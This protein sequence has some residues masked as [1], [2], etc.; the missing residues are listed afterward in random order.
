MWWTTQTSLAFWQTLLSPAPSCTGYHAPMEGP[1]GLKEYLGL[2]MTSLRSPLGQC[3]GIHYGIPSH[4][5]TCHLQIKQYLVYSL[6]CPHLERGAP[7]RG[8]SLPPFLCAMLSRASATAVT[9]W[10]SP[11][12]CSWLAFDIFPSKHIRKG[13]TNGLALC[14]EVG[15]ESP[16]LP[17]FPNTQTHTDTYTHTHTLI[18]VASAWESTISAS[19]LYT[20]VF[21]PVK[22]KNN[23][24]R[25]FAYYT[26]WLH[27][28]EM[29]RV[30]KYTETK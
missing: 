20:E 8:D 10:P 26:F 25:Q 12:F 24:R 6:Q 2:R 7:K 1:Y 18:S 11:G 16:N 15:S 13:K 9:H 5:P 28:Y 19:F 23:L 17:L 14:T 22:I 4:H 3:S 27:L 30:G 29:S 21:I